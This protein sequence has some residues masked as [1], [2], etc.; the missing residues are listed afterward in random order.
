MGSL[1]SLHFFF[2]KASLTKQE[3]MFLIFNVLS[4]IVAKLILLARVLMGLTL[5]F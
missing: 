3:R 1:P 4:A 5:I 2:L